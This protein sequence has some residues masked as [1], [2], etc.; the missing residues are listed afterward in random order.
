MRVLNCKFR[1]NSSTL[2]NARGGG[3][4][5]YTGNLRLVSST[6]SGN[7]NF[8]I[9]V[10]V[11]SGNTTATIVDST[12]SG[13]TRGGIFAD[14]APSPLGTINVY[15]STI[16]GNTNGPGI[17]VSRVTLNVSN[18]TITNNEN[19][20]ITRDISDNNGTWTVKSSLIAANGTFGDARGVFTSGGFNLIGNGDNGTGFVQRCG[21]MIKLATPRCRSIPTRRGRLARQRWTN[22]DNRTAT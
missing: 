22:T 21:V 17:R 18:S 9:E 4:Y 16:S 11:D 19:G 3:I 1:G 6:L 10:K 15:Q 2:L 7:E 14:L 13:N 20:G 12:I 8:G 5:H